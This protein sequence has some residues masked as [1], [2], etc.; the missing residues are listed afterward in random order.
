M[1]N[2]GKGSHSLPKILYERPTG[3]MVS[4]TEGEESYHYHVVDHSWHGGSPWIT[5][6]P[7]N[8][9][10]EFLKGA[11]DPIS[12]DLLN[13]EE[14][15]FRFSGPYIC[16]GRFEEGKYIPCPWSDPPSDTFS[17]CIRCILQDLPDPACIFE[18]HCHVEPCGAP[19]CQIPHIVYFTAFRSSLKV[20]M[21]QQ[22]RMKERAMEQGA[23]GMLPVLLLKDRFSAR[24]YEGAISRMLA[25]P[26]MVRSGVKLTNVSKKRDLNIV[27]E[28]LMNAREDL[29]LFWEE[30]FASSHPS[31]KVIEGPFEFDPG[32][33]LIDDYPLE[34]P[35][36]SKP[37]R[38]KGERVK[39][40]V[41]GF[42]GNY[43]FFR[44]G[45]IWAYRLSE[46]PGKVLHTDVELMEN[47]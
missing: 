15:S 29:K 21:T 6:L 5:V 45:G 37:K 38:F 4:F 47:G 34:E 3:D 42:K 2:S 11:G 17:Q 14:I 23:D 12:I 26:Q 20:G 36:P 33:I 8:R 13:L 19:F 44:Q 41:L 46:A 32:P 28:S 25:I 43:M 35:L 18:P 9:K 10:G 16:T 39:G 7:L 30:L 24:S 22:R 27:G 40:K 1:M 31:T